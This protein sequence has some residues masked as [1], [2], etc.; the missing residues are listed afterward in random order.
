[1]SRALFASFFLFIPCYAFV[2]LVKVLTFVIAPIIALPCFVVLAE[3]NKTTG[4]PSQFPGKMRE[5]L[6]PLFR[7][8][9]THDDCADAWWYSG[10]FRGV[11]RF[12]GYTQADYDSKAWFRYACRVAWLWRNPAYGFAHMV[13]F[14]Q[15]GVKKVIKHRDEDDKWDSGYPCLSW[16]TAVNGRGRVAWLFQWQWYFHGQRC[17]EVALGWKIPWDGDPQNKAMLAARISPFK[18]YAKKELS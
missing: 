2:M 4:Y 11:Q 16:W 1:M 10:K 15:T 5:F 9:S 6:I 17:L 18:K 7:Q 8:F 12:A 13:G 3:E 14:D